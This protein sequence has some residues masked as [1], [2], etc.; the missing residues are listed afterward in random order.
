MRSCHD[1]ACGSAGLLVKLQLVARELDPT[2]RVP[3]KLCGQ[4][5]Q[6]E[7][8]AVAY[9]NAIIHDMEVEIARGDTMINP[10]FKTPSGQINTHD[11]VIANPMWNQPFRHGFLSPTTPS[12]ASV[13]VAALPP[14][15][16][17]GHGSS[18]LVACLNDRG[19]RC[20]GARY[21][22]GNARLWRQA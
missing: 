20:R 6:A 18:T 16:A 22:R 3:L 19:T 14:A 13:P 17:T 12:I 4:E 15:R 11:V 5:R 9:M 7:S 1:Y 2:S 8:Y 10:K 21:R